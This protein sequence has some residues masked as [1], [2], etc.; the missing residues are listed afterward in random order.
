[1]KDDPEMPVPPKSQLRAPWL[2]LA[3]AR[4]A[5][6]AAA[7]T[8]PQDLALVS[9]EDRQLPA[10]LGGRMVRIYVPPGDRPFPTLLFCH[11][12][13]WVMG[14]LDTH[15][16]PCRRI[17]ALA[18]AMVV[19]ID[20]R[21]AP[22]HVF[23]AAADDAWNALLWLAEQSATVDTTRVG[24][25]GESAGATLAAVTAM[26]ARARGSPRICFQLL[27]YPPLVPVNRPL[28]RPG[29][30]HTVEE[31]GWY[32]Q[33]YLGDWKCA[34]DPRA[35]PVAGNLRGLPRTLIITAEH[36]PLRTEDEQFAHSLRAAGVSVR[37]QCYR[38]QDHG[39]FRQTSTPASQHASALA[40]SVFLDA[41]HEA[42]PT[43]TSLPVE[44]A[45]EHAQE[46]L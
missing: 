28:P 45:T 36:D 10:R 16:A 46:L 42:S 3:E 4:A 22:E 37:L 7:D 31:L 2:P 13:G 9:I 33:Q 1:V 39:F 15:D 41:C 30:R 38:A 21:L 44:A 25:A 24:L 11:G 34:A 26:H 32:W 18:R 35:T 8:A 40:A 12:G 14:D 29:P 23:P 43:S 17:A 19:S 20:Y 5:Y 27:V 6:R